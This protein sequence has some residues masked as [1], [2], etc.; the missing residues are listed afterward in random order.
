MTIGDSRAA[1]AFKA[2]V[3]DKDGHI[4]GQAV[5]SRRRP[6]EKPWRNLGF[7]PAACSIVCRIAP[8]P[9]DF[10]SVRPEVIQL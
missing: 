3:L 7:A 2:P 9:D 10:R 6:V 8:E 4:V 5:A 1:K